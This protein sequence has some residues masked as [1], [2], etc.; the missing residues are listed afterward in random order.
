MA[1][2]CTNNDIP[3]KK[4]GKHLFPVALNLSRNKPNNQEMKEL[5]K[6][7]W[8]LKKETREDTYFPCSLIGRINLVALTMQPKAILGGN[9]IP[10]QIGNHQIKKVNKTRKTKQNKRRA[11]NSR[12]DVEEE[13]LFSIFFFFL[14]VGNQCGIL[15]KS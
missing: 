7:N 4:L 9:A 13:E 8:T 11:P 15:S 5:C 3:K 6:E 10:S 14:L 2:I 1:F 12:E